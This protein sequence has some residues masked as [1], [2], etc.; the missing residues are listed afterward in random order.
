MNT[1]CS[2]HKCCDVYV[3]SVE[4]SL[5][6]GSP[7]HHLGQ[8]GITE[9]ESCWS[10]SVGISSSSLISP[11]SIPATCS[12][13]RSASPT[14]LCTLNSFPMPLGR[15]PVFSTPGFGINE[16]LM[17]AQAGKA[18]LSEI[19]QRKLIRSKKQQF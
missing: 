2:D 16:G 3:D 10:P 14:S 13:R 11:L 1:N 5:L 4:R 9:Q 15:V 12:R 8:K 18:R 7:G 6:G 19:L 17:S